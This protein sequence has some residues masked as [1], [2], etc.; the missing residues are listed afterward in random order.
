[1]YH[2]ENFSFIKIHLIFMK[3]EVKKVS[4]LIYRSRVPKTWDEV[5]Q[6]KAQGVDTIIN[7]QSSPLFRKKCVYYRKEEKLLQEYGIKVIYI[8]LHLFKVPTLYQLEEIYQT[9]IKSSSKTLIHCKHGVDRTGMAI[10]YWKIKANAV[11]LDEA[12]KDMLHHGFHFRWF[13]WW[14]P[15]LEKYITSSVEETSEFDAKS[16]P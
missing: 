12:I 14:I 2:L 15:Y 3:Y 4:D 5:A 1:M 13:K 16:Q 7:L 8:P 9:L 11:T 6:I 10:A